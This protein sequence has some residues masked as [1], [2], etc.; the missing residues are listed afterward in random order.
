MDSPPTVS[1]VSIRLVPEE[2][3]R[4]LRRPTMRRR[5]TYRPLAIGAAVLLRPRSAGGRW[6]VRVSSAG[7]VK[8]RGPRSL[9][10]AVARSRSLRAAGIM[11]RAA[12]ALLAPED[13]A[14]LKPTGRLA[15]A[16]S[17]RHDC[18]G[19]SLLYQ[20]PGMRGMAVIDSHERFA[21]LPAFYDSPLEFIDRAAFLADRGIPSR[22]LA[23]VTQF[24]DFGPGPD[25]RIC[26]L[27]YPRGVFHR[28][29]GGEGH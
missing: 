6:V 5:Y 16:A 12:V 19:W 21:D 15:T 14:L 27:F 23:L 8:P 20:L 17:L 10:A 9:P 25:G 2:A 11:A 13:V 3:G 7:L 28:G 1:R 18:Y 22:P 24:D 29:W 26:N 4:S